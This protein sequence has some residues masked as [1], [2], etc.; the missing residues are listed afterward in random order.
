MVNTDE[1]CELIGG[2]HEWLLIREQGHTFPLEKQEIE[3][4]TVGETVFFGFL[5]DRG[6]H[7]WR[8]NSFVFDCN[9]IV[10]DV[11]GAF[12]RKR[13]LMRMVARFSASALAAEIELARLE[14]ANEIAGL[15]VNSFP[16]AKLGRVA[17]NEANGRLAHINFDAAG[18]T[19]MA[20]IADVTGTLVAEAVF[21]NAILW[22]EK[23]GLRKK[24]P[25]NNIWIICEKRHA[26]NA[27][28]LHALLTERW[29]TKITVLEVDRRTDPTVVKELPKRKIRDLWREKAKRLTLPETPNP[30]ETAAKIISLSPNEIDVIYSKQGETLRY[31]GLPF[32]RVRTML[33]IEKAWFGVGRERRILNQETWADLGQLVENLKINRSSA[34]PNR[35][36][37]YY[38]TA[39][40]A[41]LESILRRNINLL[42]ANLILSPIYNQFRSS[43][44]KIDLLALRRDGR[45]V[46]IELKTQPDRE[47]VF[48]A[49]DYWRKI[50]LQ[51][52]RGDLEAANL[53]DGREIL[54]KSALIYLAA[55]AWSFH[56][57]FEF[58]AS[59]VSP[60]IEL[61]RFEL[62][63]N[64]RES[65][66]VIA[67]QN[68]DDEDGAMLV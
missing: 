50:E 39:P 47:M 53:F 3:I 64:W 42:D 31:M 23:L 38:R 55:P 24:K 45:L 58:F 61:W 12:G 52:R 32:A 4:E 1:L 30:S 2:H 43:N 44:D 56:R 20:A 28:K 66:R 63:E 48:Q 26:R 11:A 27:Q 17:L 57:D 59:T 8:L 34:A 25:V 36:H 41:W 67:R 13:E 29:K 6:F 62:H 33:G 60:E 21:T 35:R 65:V 9:E 7:S 22:L 18:K 37:E 5:D 49:A 54:D 46:I 14:K 10:I 16:G 19:A 68:Y 15:I 51:R 40:E